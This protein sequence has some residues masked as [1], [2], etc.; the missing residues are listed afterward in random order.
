MKRSIT[1]VSAVLVAAFTLAC[2]GSADTDLFADVPK[3]PVTLTEAHAQEIYDLAM[4]ASSEW[5]EKVKAI[6]LRTYDQN[7]SS[8]LDTA[9]EVGSISCE[10]IQSLD[11]VV[12]S[13]S[14]IYGFEPDFIWLGGE[15]GF[16][17]EMREPAWARM[18]ACG[19][20]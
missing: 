19:I 14:A 10:T 11:A 8:S 12:D 13:F 17:P 6:L 5:D 3:K 7:G 1:F 18:Q 16:T 9:E 4:P 15:V 20:Q 2:G